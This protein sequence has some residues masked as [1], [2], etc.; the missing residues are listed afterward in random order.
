MPITT[1]RSKGAPKPKPE[2]RALAI[3]LGTFAGFL[4]LVAAGL[5][6]LGGAPPPPRIGGPFKL[7]AGDGRVVTDG[8]F[9]GKYLLIY[10]GYTECPDVCPTTLQEVGKALDLLGPKA[11]AL[12]ALFITVD[13]KR[14]TPKV[15]GAYAAGFSARLIGLSGSADAIGAVEREYQIYVA[16]HRTGPGPDDYTVDHT[17]VLYL[18]GPDGRFVAPISADEP[19][20]ALAA[21]I[22]RGMS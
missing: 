20:A 14:D 1:T 16:I 15:I 6:W 17:S 10:F 19:A 18:M 21:D 4:V 13:P 12:R 3:V 2:R 22:A 8:D 9:R 5:W 7:I 11:E